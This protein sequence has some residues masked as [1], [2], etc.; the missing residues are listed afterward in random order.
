MTYDHP[1]EPQRHSRVELLLGAVMF[2]SRWLLAPFYLGM[3][4]GLLLLLLAFGRKLLVQDVVLIEVKATD[5]LSPVH[6]A[7]LLTYL[8]LSGFRIGLLMNFNVILFKQGLKR[9]VL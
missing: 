8:K 6:Q 7:Q 4:V 1:P 2:K 9:M 5:G 3:I